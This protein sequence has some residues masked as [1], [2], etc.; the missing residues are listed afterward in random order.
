MFVDK[1]LQYSIKVITCRNTIYYLIWAFMKVTGNK[2]LFIELSFAFH[3]HFQ[4]CICVEITKVLTKIG[5]V[6]GCETVN[7]WI[8]PCTNHLYWSAR[9][10]HSGNGEVISAKFYSF[11]SHVVNKHKD[12][13]NPLFN[14]CAH[15]ETIQQRKWLD[16]GMYY[17]SLVIC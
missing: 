15:D 2:D 3:F 6:S 7:E 11:L 12:L 9:T 1:F 13:D 14:K 8:K 10:T 5:K 17:F 16:K 4:L